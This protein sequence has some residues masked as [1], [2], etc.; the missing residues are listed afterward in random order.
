[1]P[2]APPTFCQASANFSKV[3]MEKVI[4]GNADEVRGTYFAYNGDFN[5]TILKKALS[6]YVEENP[7]TPSE[8]SIKIYDDC[9][10]K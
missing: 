4:A 1:M 7:L 3:V 9:K 5:M 6:N 10:A 8:F 2:P